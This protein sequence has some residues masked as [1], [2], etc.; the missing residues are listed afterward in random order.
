MKEQTS[1]TT[2]TQSKGRTM[3]DFTG[4]TIYV[5]FCKTIAPQSLQRL[6]FYRKV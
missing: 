3:I 6:H 5:G 2:E 4:K 1:A